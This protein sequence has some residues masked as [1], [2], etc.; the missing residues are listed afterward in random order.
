MRAAWQGDGYPEVFIGY[1]D[2]QGKPD[3]LFHNA[4]GVGLTR[5]RNLDMGSS[6]L[7]STT[8]TYGVALADANGDGRLD[9]YL[10]KGGESADALYVYTTCPNGL[11]VPN[12]FAVPTSTS[13]F[14]CPSI[15]QQVGDKCVECDKRTQADA[16]GKCQFTCP[17]GYI[18]DYG[19]ASCTACPVGTTYS[20]AIPSS[21]STCVA[22]SPGTISSNIGS[23][24]CQPCPIGSSQSMSMRSSCTACPAGSFAADTGMTTCTACPSGGY[25]PTVGG[26]SSQVWQACDAGKYFEGTGASSSSECNSCAAGKANPIPGSTSASVCVDCLPGL[27]SAHAGHATCHLCDAGKY[28]ST[29]ANTACRNCTAGY[30]CV[31]GASA[32]QP[33]PGGTHADQAVLTAVG[34]LSNLTSDCKV[35]PEGTSCSVGSA[36]P[37]PCLPGSIAPAARSQTCDLCGNGKFQREYGQTACDT[38]IPGFYCKEGTSEPSPCPVGHYGNATGLYSAGQCKPVL[39]D[40]WAPLG[41]ALPKPCPQS[42]FYCPGALQDEAYGGGE[43]IIMPVGESTRQE[44][45]EAIS[46]SMTLDISMDDFAAQREALKVELGE[47][48]G[49]DSSLISLEVSAARRARARL[50]QTSG[51]LQL[52]ITIA[53]TDSSGNTVD[54]ATLTSSVTAVDDNA[55]ASTIGSVIGKTVTVV[56]QPPTAATVKVT[57]AFSCPAGHYCSAGQQIPCAAGEYNPYEGNT[58]GLACLPCP[59]FSSSEAGSAFLDNC[60][61]TDGFI[62]SVGTDGR[63]TCVCP[64]GQERLYSTDARNKDKFRCVVCRMGQY[65]ENIDEPGAISCLKC[66]Q[67]NAMTQPTFGATSMTHCRCPNGKYMSAPNN[68]SNPSD[69]SC[70]DLPANTDSMGTGSAYFPFTEDLVLVPGYYRIHSMSLS[71]KRCVGR[72]SCVGGNNLTAE[73]TL[74]HQGSNETCPRYTQLCAT[75]HTGKY[76]DGAV[77]GSNGEHLLPR[78]MM[79]TVARS[80]PS[81]FSLLGRLLPHFGAHLCRVQWKHLYGL[82]A[83]LP[84]VLDGSLPR[85]PHVAAAQVCAQ[86]ERHEGQRQ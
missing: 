71:I 75:G 37:A 28:T 45:V 67:E 52:T 43:P 36:A 78:L 19:A 14:A 31:E 41:S 42:G 69:W 54:M 38:C 11:G 48:Y 9:L 25:C 64:A 7:T 47:Q 44:E 35:C 23:L 40:F 53:T 4:K 16:S 34:Y 73:C 12:A 82:P 61:C 29:S 13:C 65:K 55:L 74:N 77:I 3:M 5:I 51:G 86:G 22:C 10:T 17:M 1:N 8:R 26:A 2:A 70:L 49:V 18:R 33:C 58:T 30:L 50:L 20:T 68:R 85:L 72:D 80:R 60:T 57:T 21:E 76:C 81:W 39:I 6:L 63:S 24:S 27:Y 83:A 79:L 56:S 66:P 46:K 59:Q 32:P 15:S 84:R 62:P